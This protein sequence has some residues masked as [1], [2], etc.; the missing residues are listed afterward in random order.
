MKLGPLASPILAA[1]AKDGGASAARGGVRPAQRGTAI[2][3]W[4]LKRGDEIDPTLVVIDSLGGGSR[5]EVFAAWDRLLFCRTAVKVVRPDRL[6]SER[7]LARVEL[8]A[9]IAARLMHP[10]LVRFLRWNPAMPRPYMVFEYIGARTVADHLD[11]VG[12]LSAPESCLLGI[13]ML[14][15]LH[16]LHSVSVLHL[17]VKPGNVTTGDPP[18]LLDLSIARF[19]PGPLKL[20]HAAGT[21][22]YMAPEQCTS[23]HVS[24]LTDLWGMGATLYEALTGSPPFRSGDRDAKE[25]RERYPQ[26]V[27]RPVAP[28]ERTPGLPREL[29]AVVMSCLEKDPRAR[30]QSLIE[31]AIALERVLEGLGLDPILAWPKGIDVRPR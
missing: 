12:P 30:P 21:D 26:L 8:E 7:S 11:Q 5:Y 13:R 20:D 27:E 29:D 19:A 18:R 24:A 31:A 10:N 17:D 4:H 14:S 28:R 2:S 23:G 15:A 22:P 3:S 1:A 16:Y 25:P 9:A 6:D